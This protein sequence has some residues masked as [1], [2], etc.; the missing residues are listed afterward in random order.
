MNI[1]DKVT[2]AAIIVNLLSGCTADTGSTYKYVEIDGMTC[3]QWFWT[4]QGGISCNWDQWD[5]T[6]ELKVVTEQR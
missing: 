1:G 3:I 4:K 5:G 6:K 2:A